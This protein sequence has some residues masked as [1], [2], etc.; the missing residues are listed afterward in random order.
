MTRLH[1]LGYIMYRTYAF[2]DPGLTSLSRKLSIKIVYRR[3][4]RIIDAV[5]LPLLSYWSFLLN[6]GKSSTYLTSPCR[7]NTVLLPVY[8]G[9]LRS[10][11]SEFHFPSILPP[12]TILLIV[13]VRTLSIFYFQLRFLFSYV[14]PYPLSYIL[15]PLHEAALPA[16]TCEM[17]H[18]SR[19]SAV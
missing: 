10:D 15:L 16:A 17:T 7:L 8:K 13:S 11:I 9:T 2:S 3:L 12:L 4:G 14:R 6:C 1:L 5:A 18:H 19:W